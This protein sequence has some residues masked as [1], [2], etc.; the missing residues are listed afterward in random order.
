L[1]S[2]FHMY[3]IISFSL[4]INGR[5]GEGNGGGDNGPS[6]GGDGNHMPE[7]GQ[8]RGGPV[9]WPGGSHYVTDGNSD[10]QQNTDSVNE[11]TQRIADCLHT[12]LFPFPDL[13]DDAV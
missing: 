4:L 8:G 10:S 5:G 11:D 1:I 7:G 3:W 12:S 13:S 2:D 6:N 9:I